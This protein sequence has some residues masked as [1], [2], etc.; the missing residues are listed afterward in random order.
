M[1][2]GL[3][4]APAALQ[5]FVNDMFKDLLDDCVIGYLDDILIYS[6]DAESHIE[7]VWDCLEQRN[8]TRRKG[9]SL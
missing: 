7:H 8:S 6:N 4:N 9:N 5:C 1:P 2:F 3:T